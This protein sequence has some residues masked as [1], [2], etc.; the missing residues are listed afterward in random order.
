MPKPIT[1]KSTFKIDLPDK[2][3]GPKA[4]K[5][6]GPQ[7][8]YYLTKSKDKGFWYVTPSGMNLYSSRKYQIDDPVCYKCEGTQTWGV[9]HVV[10]VNSKKKTWCG[11]CN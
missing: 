8:L 10:K 7:Y 3:E 11:F 6:L 4:P 9:W 1:N 5:C 2:K